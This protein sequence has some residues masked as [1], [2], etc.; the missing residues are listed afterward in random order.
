[1]SHADDLGDPERIDPPVVDL[2][3]AVEREVAV[4]LRALGGLD[5]RPA[6]ACARLLAAWGVIAELGDRH[7]LPLLRRFA[8]AVAALVERSGHALAERAERG[9]VEQAVAALPT[10]VADLDLDPARCDTRHLD[11][12]LRRIEQC[13][14][15]SLAVAADAPAATASAAVAI[16]RAVAKA[17]AERA[18][19]YARRDRELL[20][21]LVQAQASEQQ[22]QAALAGLDAAIKELD[23]A[24]DLIRDRLFALG[25]ATGLQLVPRSGQI[26]RPG[27]TEPADGDGLDRELAVVLAAALGQ[28][29]QQL[30]TARTATLA[31]ALRLDAGVR[32]R[33]EALEAVAGEL[34]TVPAIAQGGPT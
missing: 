32:Q 30:L 24:V 33:L 25:D 26:R 2:V 13:A 19:A 20:A 15:V 6:A 7:T 31:V 17:L 29:V 14:D 4:M 3:N 12:L 28:G 10:L 1:M 27:Q 18:D 5:R 22:A 8:G 23:R 21:R 16:E 11:E 34:A 9:L